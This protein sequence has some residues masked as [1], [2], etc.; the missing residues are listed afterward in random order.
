[1][2][3]TKHEHLAI[4]LGD[5]LGRLN[6]GER[7]DVQELAETYKTS[8]RT[9]QR[10]LN[11]R[12]ANLHYIEAGPRYFSLDKSKQ[13]YLNSEDIRRFARFA[14]V[15]D[16]FPEVD[17]QFFQEKLNQSIMVKGFQYENIRNKQSEFNLLTK[18]IAN[19]QTVRFHYSKVSN[20]ES[21]IYTIEPYHLVNKNGIW[22]LVGLAQHKQKTF[23]F[24][25]ISAP[26]MLDETFTVDHDLYE[27]IRQTDS[28]FYGNQLSEIII[29]INAHA[30][31]YFK[32]RALLPNQETVREL[33]NGSLLLA[34]KKVH[35]MEVIPIV[36]YWIPH[37]HIVSPAELQQQMEQVLKRYLD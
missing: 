22:Y 31:G 7:L 30:A 26:E 4:R 3:A 1:M 19:H 27:S 21:K 13:G 5:I 37:A 29:Q 32:R 10:D 35:A 34:C 14:S 9:I 12:L 6:E 18:A 33:D 23:C 15:Q 25:Q 17:R 16:L 2:S 11:T 36:Q 20:H 28:I 8:I 24:T